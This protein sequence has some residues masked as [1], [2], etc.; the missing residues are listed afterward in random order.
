M[1][2]SAS[3]FVILYAKIKS[4]LSGIASIEET[5]T[6][7][8]ITTTSGGSFSFTIPNWHKHDNKVVLDLLTQD[9]N[10]NLTFDTKK[11]ATEDDLK[12]LQT[13]LEALIK[14]KQ[15]ILTAGDNISI[16]NN[17]ISS[18][19]IDDSLKTSKTKT[20]SIDKI[21]D[22]LKEKQKKLYFSQP[23]SS[24]VLEVND[25]LIENKNGKVTLKVYDVTNKVWNELSGG[26]TNNFELNEWSNSTQ[27]K[28]N[29]YVYTNL[30]LYKALKNH[31]STSDFETD[32]NNGN[33]ELIIG[34][35]SGSSELTKNI[36]SNVDVGNTKAN[37]VFKAGM[38]FDEYVQAVHVAYLK[39]IIN[40]SILPT[41]T[42]YK[43]GD[44]LSSINLIADIIKKSENIKTIKYYVNNTLIETK[45]NT[46]DTGII[47][48]GEFTC[49][50]ST[51]IT[52]NTELKAIVNDGKT[53]TP[54]KIVKIEFINPI[55]VGL[56]SGN[57]TEVLMKKGNYT[58]NN[59][60][61]TN[62]SVIF[63]YPASYG[64]LKSI[65]DANN[66]ENVNTF[67]K[68]TEQLNGVT[69][70]VYTSRKATLTNF[71]YS[72]IF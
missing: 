56:E 1:A 23:D 29:E 13:L 30:K 16:V 48:G 28:A 21:L 55:Y 63:K 33:W 72:F 50:Y 66:F 53:D 24:I 43:I 2:F 7:F 25:V 38:T 45:D 9:S 46:T 17:K 51:P 10:G 19:Q 39:P 12:K 27:Y 71:K 67:T 32:L 15:D 69:Y 52:T 22:L 62:D 64:N 20:Y 6:G 5:S 60:N 59:I 44:S 35:S 57:L 37:F 34:G 68:T 65:L 61:C 26:T 31:T 47:N 49:G 58:Y 11:I 42:L 70:N 54:S 41:K 14:K 36:T 8:K 4:A 18:N 40:F 3:T